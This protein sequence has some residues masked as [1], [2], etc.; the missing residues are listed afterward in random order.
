MQGSCILHT[1]SIHKHVKWCTMA[2]A[3]PLAEGALSS[4]CPVM[5]LLQGEPCTVLHGSAAP[6]R[7][8]APDPHHSNTLEHGAMAI[9][10][11]TRSRSRAYSFSCWALRSASAAGFELR[12]LRRPPVPSSL[13][14]P[15]LGLL[16]RPPSPACLLCPG[17]IPCSVT[18]YDI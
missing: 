12:R 9:P 17:G 1:H 7:Q 6:S 16:S 11:A 13:L 2:T 8:Q 14:S 18:H 10:R 5:I 4:S 3:R 15:L